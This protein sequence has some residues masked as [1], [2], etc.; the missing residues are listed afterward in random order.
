MVTASYLPVATLL[1]ARGLGAST[2]GAAQIALIVAGVLLVIHGHAAGRAAG[3]NGIRLFAVT[4][5]AGLLGVAMIV[6]KTLL[7]HHHY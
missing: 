4:A 2:V 7:Q 6:L 3:L 5:M 1:V